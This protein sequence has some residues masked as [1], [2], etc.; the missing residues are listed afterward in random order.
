M[1]SLDYDLLD[2]SM[3]MNFNRLKRLVIHVHGVENNHKGLSENSWEHF[4]IKNPN[5]TVRITLVC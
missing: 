3:L 1:I 4:K 2:E 5:A